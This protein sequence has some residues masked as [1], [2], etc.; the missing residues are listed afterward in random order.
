MNESASTETPFFGTQLSL[1]GVSVACLCK[2]ALQ[3][4]VLQD[5]HNVELRIWVRPPWEG[6]LGTQGPKYSRT[7]TTPVRA[8]GSQEVDFLSPNFAEFPP[9]PAHP[10]IVCPSQVFPARWWLLKTRWLHTAATITASSK[11]WK[12]RQ[13]GLSVR[14][15]SI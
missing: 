9:C 2:A 5:Q 1:T 10:T 6:G 7:I 11:P 14:A 12:I 15:A 3:A 13:L 4:E 8:P